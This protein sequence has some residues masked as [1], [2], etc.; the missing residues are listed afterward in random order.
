MSSKTDR[1]MARWQAQRWILDAVIRT[2]GMEWDQPRLAYMS[3]PGGGEAVM[4]FR[5]V[6]AR[7]KKAADIDREFA[8]AARRRQ[9]RAERYESE[10]R[11]LAAGESYFIAM[12]L[13]ASARWPIFEINDWLLELEEKMN[14]CYAKYIEYAQ[15]PVEAIRIPLGDKEM[16]AYLH[17]PRK[18]EPG[19]TFPCVLSIDGMDACKE[20]MVAMYGDA[21]LNRGIAVLAFDGPGQGECCS[22]PIL[23]TETNHMDAALAAMKVIDDHPALDE[24]NVC[25]RGTSFGTYFGTL[26]AVALKDRIK[27]AALVGVCQEPG[28]NTI[29]NMASPSFKLRFMFM[30]GYDDED[31]FDA[32]ISSFDLRKH[33]G[34]LA[35]PY[36]VVAGEDD[37][38]S[39]I[40]HTEELFTHID[41]PKRLMVYEGANHAVG[42]APSVA[43]GPNRNTVLGEWFLDR[44]ADKP[45][46]SERVYV[47]ATGRETAEAF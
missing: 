33:V 12:L 34:G 22:I 37:Q 47:D 45:M 24:T 15:H 23:V 38:L 21:L 30:A 3:A 41:V 35:A 6:A 42:D 13:W 7:V 20:N 11:T 1:L 27:G 5:T 16:P 44:F 8:R 10:G 36:M 46:A 17:L 40:E 32:F 14:H 31:E 9:A 26:A 39:P 28:C 18:P 19:E 4:D 2:V 25:V 29:F 43:L